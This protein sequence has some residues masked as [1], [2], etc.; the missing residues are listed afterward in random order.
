MSKNNLD[1]QVWL[2]FIKYNGIFLWKWYHPDC[3]KQELSTETTNCKE[4]KGIDKATQGSWKYI[5]YEN[6]LNSGKVLYAV[7]LLKEILLG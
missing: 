5:G 4:K 1:F 2:T 7:R 3:L 6:H